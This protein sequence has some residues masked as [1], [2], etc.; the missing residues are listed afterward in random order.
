MKTIHENGYVLLSNVLNDNELDAALSCME[1]NKVDYL[2]FKHFI[3]N[4]F[5]LKIKQL[6]L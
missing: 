2:R 1:E 3:D 4:V 5:F 6:N